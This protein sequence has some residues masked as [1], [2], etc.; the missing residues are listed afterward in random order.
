MWRT[1]KKNNSKKDGIDKSG[2]SVNT[3]NYKKTITLFIMVSIMIFTALSG[4]FVKFELEYNEDNYDSSTYVTMKVTGFG[5]DDEESKVE[6]EKT[7]ENKKNPDIA[8]VAAPINIYLREFDGNEYNLIEL[9]EELKELL[10]SIDGKATLF[11]LIMLVPGLMWIFGVIV[12]WICIRDILL[13]NKV[14]K[15][16]SNYA[17]AASVAELIFIALILIFVPLT[18]F[19]KVSMNNL[20]IIICIVAF[21]NIFL[22]SDFYVKQL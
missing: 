17:K 22:I 2:L 11:A 10:Y 13:L 12:T 18:G 1:G 14:G 7:E 8:M 9:Y 19:L 16:I 3:I 21:L 20:G 4:I 6:P 15:N 5:N